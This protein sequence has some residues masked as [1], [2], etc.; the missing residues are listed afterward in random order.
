MNPSTDSREAE[1]PQLLDASLISE[2]VSSYWRVKVLDEIGSTQSELAASQP[3]DG[4]LLTAEYQSAGRGR[5]DRTFITERSTALTFSFYIEPKRERSEWG[6]LSLLAGSAV[7][8]TLN[9]VTNSNRYTTKWPNDILA[10]DKKIA[11]LLSEVSGDGVIIGIGINV[12]TKRA[13][14]PVPTSSSIAIESDLTIDRNP[15]LITFLNIFEADF[16]DWNAGSYPLERYRAVSST[17]GQQVSALA[18][19]GSVQSGRAIDI[20]TSGALLLEAGASISVGDITH[21]T[22]DG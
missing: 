3:S 18:P 8:R 11:G 16:A 14:L 19:D 9:E 21:L 5:L 13:N 17:L 20:S 22:I 15:L 2:S 6:F 7:A 12:T 4:D 1:L 10:G